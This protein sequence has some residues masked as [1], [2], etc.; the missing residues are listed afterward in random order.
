MAVQ[1]F[2]CGNVVERGACDEVCD[3]F[4]RYQVQTTRILIRVLALKTETILL[5]WIIWEGSKPRFCPL[6]MAVSDFMTIT[7]QFLGLFIKELISSLSKNRQKMEVI[8]PFWGKRC[9]F[10]TSK[11][12]NFSYRIFQCGFVGVEH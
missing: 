8:H 7:L 11:F 2:W 3:L 12:V 4:W 5:V 10:K 6:F 1:R 9:G